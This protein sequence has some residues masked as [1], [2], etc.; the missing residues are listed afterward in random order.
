ME[1]RIELFIKNRDIMKSNFRWDNST[2]YPLCACLYTEQGIEIDVLKIKKCKVIIKNNANLFSPFRGTIDLALAT[3]LSL[4]KEPENKF[5]KILKAYE[6][7]RQEFRSSQYLPVSAFVMAN[8]V[9]PLEYEV[10]VRKSEE[11]YQ[12]MKNEH[13]FLTSAEDSS[14]AVMFALSTLTV[15]KVVDEMESCYQQ[16]KGNF[17]SANAVQ[18]LSHTLALGE[19]NTIEKCN[20]V[21]DIFNG[22][23]ER[24]CKFGTGVELAV[25]GVLA[26]ITD[27]VK[28]TIEDIIK[29]NEALLNSKGFGAFGT[30]KTQRMMYSAIL[31][32]QEYKKSCIDNLMN[33]TSINSITSIII[34]QQVAITAAIAAS[35]AASSS[36]N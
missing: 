25:L 2:L 24:R 17:F 15:D 27:D 20:R 16:L 31:V 26:L 36:S 14:F 8:M 30:G 21:I 34:A 23:K 22:L 29:V 12:R 5:Q 6:I 9:E 3:M 28:Q 32:E 33:I 18:S 19:E 1:Q 13:P 7:L 10:I 35:A 4:D 11:I